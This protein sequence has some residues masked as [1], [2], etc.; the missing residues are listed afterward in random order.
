MVMRFYFSEIGS[1]NDGVFSGAAY[2]E[3]INFATPLKRVST[4]I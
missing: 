1:L 2:E 4:R 3:I